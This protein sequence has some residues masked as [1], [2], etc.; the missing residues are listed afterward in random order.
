MFRRRLFCS[1]QKCPL[2]KAELPFDWMFNFS[3]LKLWLN[4]YVP[5]QHL[6]NVAR[7]VPQRAKPYRITTRQPDWNRRFFKGGLWNDTVWNATQ[8]PNERTVSCRAASRTGAK[9]FTG[10]IIIAIILVLI[11]FY[12]NFS[13]KFMFLYPHP[14][15][16]FGLT[17]FHYPLKGVFLARS[18]VCVCSFEVLAPVIEALAEYVLLPITSKW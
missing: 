17:R 7:T 6:A 16:V 2:C 4:F 18:C 13:A 3:P 15:V 8:Q 9:T 1:S 14:P 12:A 5:N 11:K 10:A